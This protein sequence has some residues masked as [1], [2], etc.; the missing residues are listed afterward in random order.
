MDRLDRARK[1]CAVLTT[2]LLLIR[3]AESTWNAAGRW[4]GHGDPPLSERGR[5]QAAAL[6]SRWGETPV[7]AFFASDLQRARETAAALGTAFGREPVWDPRLRE[8]DVGTWTGLTRD[9]I[10]ERDGD[11]LKRFEAEE[12]DVQPG[13]G[14]SRRGPQGAVIAAGLDSESHRPEQPET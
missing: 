12:P 6:A 1:L 10:A 14:E 2:R 8:L 13:G 3:H 4:Q 9:A 11:I 5:E 7:D